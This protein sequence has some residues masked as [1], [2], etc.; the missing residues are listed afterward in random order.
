MNPHQKNL[1]VRFAGA[2]GQGV[3]T[4][5]DL[6]G[7]AALRSGRFAYAY[8]DAESRIRG[9]VNFSQVR[10]SSE[11]LMGVTQRCDLLVALS[12][13]AQARCADSLAEHGSLIAARAAAHPR[14]APF[15]LEQLAARA[16]SRAVASTVGLAVAC[17]LAG[18]ERPICLGV[19][20]ERFA[21]GGALAEKNAQAVLAGYEAV[22]GWIRQ[23]R[24]AVPARP[25][26]ASR[27]LWIAGHEAISLGAVAGGVRFVAGYP[28]SPATGILSDLSS[29]AR[30]FGILVEQAE[31]EP[32]AIN[33]LAGA[34]YA[35]AR[36]MTATSGGGFCLMCEGVSLLGMIECPAVVVLA[37]R[38]GPSTGQP[39]RTA[40]GDLRLALHA[41]HG[42]FPRVILAPRDVAD[43][44]ELTARAFDIAERY[45]VTVFVLSDQLLQDSRAVVPPFDTAGLPRARHLLQPD[46]L[47]AMPRYQRY[48]QTASGV[49]PQAAPGSSRHVVVVDSDEHDEDGHLTES[50]EIAARMAQKRLRKA[51]LIRNAKLLAA[52][53]PEG[54]LDGRPLVLSWGSTY[55]TLAEARAVLM[56]RGGDFAHLHL[57]QLWPLPADRLKS[58]FERASSLAVVECNPNGELAGLLEQTTLTR[59][60]HL[61]TRADGRPMHVDELTERI[62]SEVLR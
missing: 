27:H 29:W 45:G 43:G 12:A 47:K 55:Q 14:A 59:I 35:G 28:M 44:F 5:A 62:E 52:P 30:D 54:D 39:T 40:Q 60:D 57:R 61:L 48:A 42:F 41:G 32:A 38:P 49:S 22:L 25:E 4:A 33:M 36:A 8:A 31:D 23:E 34:S 56:D 18:I 2:A 17:A 6:L 19:V 13:E 10:V 1:R 53:E 51:E 15:D 16:G 58:A 46:Q 11:P 26:V 50:A 21:S 3:Q 20:R 37:Q 7:R 24:Y 9:G